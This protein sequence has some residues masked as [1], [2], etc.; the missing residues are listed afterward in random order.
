M[1]SRLLQFDTDLLLAINGF[2]NSFL[3]VFLWQVSARATW[4]PLYVAMLALIVVAYRPQQRFR[5]DWWIGIAVVI[6][7]FAACVGLADFISSGVIKHAVCRLRPTQEPALEPLLHIVNGYHGGRYGFVSSHAAN[8]F[9]TA[10]L[11]S[12]LIRQRHSTLTLL[13]WVALN[14]WSRMYLGVHYPG[15]IIGGLAVGA[16]VAL[17]IY[18]LLHITPLIKK[19]DFSSEKPAA[20][21]YIC[22]IVMGVTCLVI[23]TVAWCQ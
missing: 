18:G 21:A 14:C 5:R 13:C 15:D 20:V 8:T 9:A 7:A 11:F 12:L 4:I 16:V 2:H 23:A 3:D 17:A 1:I 19:E 10:L 22:E 6:L